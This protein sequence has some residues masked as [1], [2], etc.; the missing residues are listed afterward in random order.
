M[1]DDPPSGC[2]LGIYHQNFQVPKMEGFLF[3]ESYIQGYFGGGKLPLDKPY[4]YSLYKGF[5]IPPF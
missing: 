1:G 5:R 2:L 4:P 3:P